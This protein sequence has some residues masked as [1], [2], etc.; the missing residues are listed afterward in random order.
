MLDIRFIKDN[1]KLVKDNLKKKDRNEKIVDELLNHYESSLSLKQ[2][3]EKLRNTRNKLSEEINKLI[4]EKKD[5]KD[6]IKQV[7]DIPLKIKELE[8]KKQ[9]IDDKIRELLLKIPNIMHPKVPKGKDD[10]YNK[11]IKT[12][13]KI[14]KFSFQIKNHVELGESLNILNFD[15]SALISGNGFY[16]LKGD[17]ALLNQAL[18][19]F[20]IDHMRKKKYQYIEPPL[21]IHKDVA[22]AAGDLEA[23]KLALYKLENEELF[24][25]PTAEHAI[26]GMHSNH[27]FKE[28]ELPKKYFAYSMCFRREIGSHGINEKGL[29]RTHQF[30]KIEQFVFCHPKDSWKIYDELRK[31]TEE[32][33]KKLKLPY[34]VLEICTGDLGDWKARSEDLEVYRPTTKD[35]GEVTSLSNCTDY[36]A[37]ELNIKFVDEKGEKQV[38]HTLNNTAIATSRAL[39]SIMEHYQ[40]KEGNIKIPLVLQKYMGGKKLISKNE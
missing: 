21:M 11:V 28:E 16:Y 17:L 1:Q 13:G 24:L 22:A 8:E 3:A 29:W 33:F 35:Y 26:L 30:N 18:I 19:Q 27:T 12:E 4:K 36:Q 25:I 15:S 9:N 10:S 5:A 38:V 14:P 23:F 39:V 6:K 37:R 20:T 2:D 32:I 7:R 31:N 34:H 40:T